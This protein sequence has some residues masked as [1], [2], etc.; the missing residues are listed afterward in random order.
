MKNTTKIAIEKYYEL[1]NNSGSHS[2]SLSS[3]MDSM[4]IDKLQIDACFLV[5]HMLQIYLRNS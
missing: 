3:V 1:K 5:I 4:G 2:P